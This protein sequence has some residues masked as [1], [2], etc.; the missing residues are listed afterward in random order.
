MKEYWSNLTTGQKI[1]YII[2]LII[3]IF[4]V[5]FAVQNWART[6]VNFVFFSINVP[7]TLLILISLVGGYGLST[8]FDYRKFKKKDKEIK[9]LKN[10]L[11]INGGGKS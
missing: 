3:V 5:I 11:D 9:S 7:K 8:L 2:S 4:V 10:Q 1:K 6:E